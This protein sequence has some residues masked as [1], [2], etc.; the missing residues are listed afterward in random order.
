MGA[1]VVQGSGWPRVARF[2]SR[3]SVSRSVRWALVGLPQRVV[4]RTEG[5]DAGGARGR[6]TVKV[7]VI[8]AEVDAVTCGGFRQAGLE[9][10]FQTPG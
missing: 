6:Y 1:G 8:A 2:G 3:V 9:Q 4:M 7:A 5:A 10:S